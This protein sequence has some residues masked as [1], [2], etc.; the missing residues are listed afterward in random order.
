MVNYHFF[1]GELLVQSSFQ[2]DQI[3]ELLTGKRLIDKLGE[4]AGHTGCFNE[5]KVS[6]VIRYSFGS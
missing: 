6:Q 4:E 1:G 2:F 5:H 3:M